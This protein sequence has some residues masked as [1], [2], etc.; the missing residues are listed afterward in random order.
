MFNFIAQFHS[1]NNTLHSSLCTVDKSSYLTVIVSL[2]L[3]S[4]RVCVVT[5]V[6]CVL[7]SGSGTQICV[8]HWICGGCC[9]ISSGGD[10]D[11]RCDER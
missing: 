11:R 10:S 2:Y 1:S 7:C 9:A 4:E 8:S 5:D 6:V 3:L